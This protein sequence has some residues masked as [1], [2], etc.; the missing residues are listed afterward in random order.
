MSEQT[1]R[2]KTFDLMRDL[3]RRGV[4]MDYTDA[5]TIR[6]AA[7]TLHRWN[8]LECGDSDQWKAWSIERDET[9]GRAYMAMHFYGSRSNGATS[10]R[11][12]IADREAGALRRV[13]AICA[14]Y[15]AHYFHQTDPRGA[16]LYI[17][18]QPLTD[19]TYSGQGVAA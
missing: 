5:N 14:K 9:D 10:T 15:G 16:S 18:A 11:Y 1:A 17:A 8:E 12:R 13:A 19:Q 2:A 3:A 7:L 4:N 6:R